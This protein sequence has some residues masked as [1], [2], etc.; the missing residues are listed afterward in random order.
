MNRARARPGGFTLIE[1]MIVISIMAIVFA[2]GVPSLFRMTRKDAM[3][4]ALGDILEACQ[5]ARAEAILRDTIMEIKFDLQDGGVWELTVVPGPRTPHDPA[6]L[7]ELGSEPVVDAPAAAAATPFFEAHFSDQILV[8][9]LGVNFHDAIA[10]KEPPAPVRFFPNGTCDEF[11][12]VVQWPLEQQWRK[13]TLDVIT[14][15]PDV[16]VVR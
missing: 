10:D 11:A 3:R 7:P 5:R 8:E 2:L 1:I 16:E 12:M 15:Q 14:G 13:I 6:N 9:V 4:Q